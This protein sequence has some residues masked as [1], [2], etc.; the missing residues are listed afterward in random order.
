[1]NGKA[2]GLCNTETDSIMHLDSFGYATSPWSTQ[3]VRNHST[4]ARPAESAWERLR[5]AG[6]VQ[7]VALEPWERRP[8]NPFE[9]GV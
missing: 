9:P 2:G 6:L 1:M 7:R 8:F 3:P 5:G 4:A